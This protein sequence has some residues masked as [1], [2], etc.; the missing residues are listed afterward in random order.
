LDEA[1]AQE[2]ALDVQGQ[3]ADKQL[4][5]VSLIQEHKAARY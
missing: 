3:T 1:R 5:A 4:E 2:I